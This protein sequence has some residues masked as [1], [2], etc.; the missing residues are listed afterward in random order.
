[1]PEVPIHG[2]MHRFLYENVYD[3][4]MWNARTDHKDAVRGAIDAQKISPDTPECP[5][6][7]LKVTPGV[8]KERQR[9]PK[10]SPTALPEPPKTLKKEVQNDPGRFFEKR[11]TPSC[12]NTII[13]YVFEGS[14]FEN[15][16]IYYVFVSSETL[17]FFRSDENI[18][19]YYVLSIDA[20]PVLAWE[21]EARSKEEMLS[22]KFS[23]VLPNL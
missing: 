16:I 19:I 2:N 1:M 5:R 21:R 6:S 13:Y 14:L 11:S 17:I 7:A 9:R 22:E 3:K 20:E 12:E 8:P 18:I 10:G 15:T 23:K 4:R